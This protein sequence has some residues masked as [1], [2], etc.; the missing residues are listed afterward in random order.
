MAKD[1][2]TTIDNPAVVPLRPA[3]AGLIAA[4]AAAAAEIGPVPKRAQ[5]AFHQYKYVAMDDLMA[6]V[7]PVLARHGLVITQ[8]ENDRATLDRDGAIAVRF[9]FMVHHVSGEALG[10]LQRTGLSKCRDS[11]GGLD[12]RALRKAS[13]AAR[14][15]VLLS[16][17]GIAPDENEDADLGE[18]DRPAR[19]PAPTGRPYQRP[20]TQ[21]ES[22]RRR[23]ERELRESALAVSP[24]QRETPAQRLHRKLQD[25]TETDRDF[26]AHERAKGGTP[27]ARKLWAVDKVEF[28]IHLQERERRHPRR[29]DNPDR[30]EE[31]VARRR[32]EREEFSAEDM[33]A[34]MGPEPPPHDG[35]DIPASL[36]RRPR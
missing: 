8:S 22:P 6:C 26:I 18:Y 31:E 23:L 32:A 16:L 4:L 30:N 10:P 24:P 13:T 25:G 15:D 29:F 7:T 14:K 20:P 9:D 33:A 21:S 1:A 11:K 19:A 2:N 27:P 17:L 5:H 28:D 12:D 3:P 36:R 35:M 34:V